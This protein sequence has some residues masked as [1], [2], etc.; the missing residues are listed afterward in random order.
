[1]YEFL[2]NNII[3]TQK[4]VAETKKNLYKKPVMRFSYGAGYTIGQIN[5]SVFDGQVLLWSIRFI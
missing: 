2:I 1:M 5:F 3:G 4:N